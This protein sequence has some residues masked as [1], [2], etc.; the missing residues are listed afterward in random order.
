MIENVFSRKRVTALFV[1]L[2]MVLSCLVGIVPVGVKVEAATNGIQEKI[3]KLLEVYP[4]G[5]YFSKSGGACGD[6]CGDIYCTN[7]GL[8]Y[9][10]SRN[11]LPAGRNIDCGQCCSFARYA[12]TYIFGHDIDSQTIKTNSGTPQYG[13]CV[14]FD[15]VFGDHW[16]ICL[17][18]YG[19]GES[20]Y[21]YES[22]YPHPNKV[23]YRK[24][25][26]G[27][28]YLIKK[29]KIKALYHATN[30][31]E[32]YNSTVAPTQPSQPEVETGV[33]LNSVNFPDAVFRQYVSDNF[34]KDNNGL[35]S[36]EEI[37]QIKKIDVSN[38]GIQSLKGL[39]YFTV[40]I[41]LDCS[42]NQLTSLSS[43]LDV[44]GCTALEYLDCSNNQ[45]TSL[46]VNNTALKYLDCGSNQLQSLYFYNIT[47]EYLDCS[48]TCYFRGAYS[49]LWR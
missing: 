27:G 36:D 11:G 46:S 9:I 34:D 18:S 37:S 5:S 21:A 12:Y 25:D 19:D 4:D 3:E 15:G 30:Y 41:Y 8:K 26:S 6:S 13:D 31:D 28:K 47:L 48:S 7:C 39:G 32:V 40:L 2:A 23:A 49:Q 44:G 33:E 43:S 10:P 22:N 42:N 45:L 35:L 24:S 38:K 16:A 17:D 29:S 20:W 14:L 1:A